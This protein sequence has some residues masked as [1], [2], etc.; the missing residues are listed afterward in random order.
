MI[1]TITILFLS[2][3]VAIWVGNFLSQ[4]L[5]DVHT[6]FDRKPFNCRPCL[7]FHTTWI[8]TASCAPLFDSIAILIGGIV[9]AFG[10]YLVMKYIDNKMIQK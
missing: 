8:L 1:Q 3:L 10:V 7:S 4:A 2:L 9:L 5:P 6:I